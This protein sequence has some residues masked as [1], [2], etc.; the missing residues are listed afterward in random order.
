MSSGCSKDVADVHTVG[1]CSCY[2]PFAK[3]RRAHRYNT[4][5]CYECHMSTVMEMDSGQV[6]IMVCA[7]LCRDEGGVECQNVTTN[8]QRHI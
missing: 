6:D 5:T 3:K 2:W 1:Y 4:G 7:V 8:R